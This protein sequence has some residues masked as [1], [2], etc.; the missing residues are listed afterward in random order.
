MSKVVCACRDFSQDD[1][2]QP[3]NQW[4]GWYT[5]T[6]LRRHRQLIADLRVM[7]P[8]LCIVETQDASKSY[9]A[10]RGAIGVETGRSSSMIVSDYIVYTIYR[11]T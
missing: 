6:S 8:E 4:Q 7:H 10:E 9:V 1:I 5:V 11:E 3:D 2:K